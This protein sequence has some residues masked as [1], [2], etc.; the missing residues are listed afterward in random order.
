[1]S[2]DLTQSILKEYLS[3]DPETGVFCWNK[4]TTKFSN[5]NI[6]DVAGTSNHHKG[7][8]YIKFM[9][10]Q[11]AAHRLA[12]LYMYGDLPDKEIDHI[13]RNR[14]DNRICNLRDVHR[15]I[16][17]RNRSV[18]S[19]NTSG[20]IGVSFCKKSQKWRAYFSEHGKQRMMGLFDSK[21]D[22]INARAYAVRDWVAAQMAPV[23]ELIDE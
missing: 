7:Y 6:G 21:D 16:N 14:S 12:W 1:M 5:V 18:S 17:C 19:V 22:A 20:H 8:V 11:Y 10:R 23:P 13:N 2:Q 9:G 15:T 4:K 3:Y